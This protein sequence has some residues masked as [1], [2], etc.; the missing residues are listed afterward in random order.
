MD[1]K[2]SRRVFLKGSGL[3][4]GGAVTSGTLAVLAAHAAWAQDGRRDRRRIAR[5]SDYGELRPRP[6]QD[7]RLVL[8][9]PGGFDYSTFSRTGERFGDGLVVPR[10][11]DG[12][13]CFPGPG[14]AL[15]LIRNHELRNAAG[16]VTLGV[17]VPDALKY[18]ARAMGGCMTLD[19]DPRSQRLVRQFAS[20]GG[21]FVNCAGGWSWQRTGWITCEETTAGP[22]TTPAPFG[23][24][25]GYCFFV[26]AAADTALPAVPI[27]WL[28]RFAH[29]AALAD[30]R[31]TVYLTEDAG[32]NSGFYRAVP[33]RADDL[34]S[35]GTL[36]LLAIRG[37]PHANLARG[38]T[39]GATL[40]VEWVRIDSPDPDLEG[41]AASCFDRGRGK[42][43]A[44][45]NR[46]EGAYPG[47]D[48][49]S[50]YFVSTSGGERLLGQLWH[51][52]PADAKGGDRLA[53][54]FESPAQ[55][56]LDSPDNLC[57]TPSGAIL[58]CEDDA[59]PA[60]ALAGDAHPL[61][62]GVKD[63]NRLIGLGPG[64]EPFEFAVNILNDGEFAGACFSPDGGILFVNLFGDAT[65]G[66]GMTCAIRGPWERGPL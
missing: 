3:V 27:R 64:G 25:H 18:D 58:F 17:P 16:N 11:H 39:V 24:P 50:V 48:G 42:G 66:S 46:L 61:A 65:P 4:A 43:G 60:P 34:A 12:M 14:G 20:I 52:V 29:E 6:D 33:N 7:G 8:A 40:P 10:N 35:G 47:H 19:F 1:F 51:Y 30:A 9:L 5:H 63:V 44:A 54:V 56:V 13:A 45:F 36:E 2:P 31:G 32:L 49:R 37:K 38:Q 59:N 62:P 22:K 23:Q 15:R 57:V 53:L 28:G 26:P 21:T 41:G 55:S